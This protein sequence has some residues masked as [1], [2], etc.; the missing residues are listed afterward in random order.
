MGEECAGDRL[1]K[2]GHSISGLGGSD[3][4]VEDMLARIVVQS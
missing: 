1:A 3:R 4:G 2:M